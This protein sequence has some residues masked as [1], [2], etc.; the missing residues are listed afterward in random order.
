MAKFTI[1]SHSFVTAFIGNL[2]SINTWCGAFFLI[3]EY[4][5]EDYLEVVWGREPGKT[6]FGKGEGNEKAAF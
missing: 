4:F 3:L 5:K 6:D 2:Y 1:A